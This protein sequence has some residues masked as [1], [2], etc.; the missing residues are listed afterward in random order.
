MSEE[1]SEGLRGF[2]RGKYRKYLGI[3]VKTCVGYREA[4]RMDDVK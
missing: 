4:K 1:G 2:F 3:F